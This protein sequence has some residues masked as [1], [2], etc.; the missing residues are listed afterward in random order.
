MERSQVKVLIKLNGPEEAFK[1]KRTRVTK[2]VLLV[3]NRQH[4]IVVWEQLISESGGGDGKAE[5]DYV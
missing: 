1:D 2:W 3:G 5:Q 4:L